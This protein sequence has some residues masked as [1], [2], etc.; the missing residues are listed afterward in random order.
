MAAETTGN[1]PESSINE[2]VN[3]SVEHVDTS[4]A[5]DVEYLIA[6]E[7]HHLVILQARPFEVRY[8]DS[9]RVGDL[10]LCAFHP[11]GVD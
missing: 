7:D 9:Q 8:E 3:D 6:G 1:Q 10:D 2:S 4:D 11:A 5:L